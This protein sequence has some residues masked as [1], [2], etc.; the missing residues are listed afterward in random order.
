M[1]TSGINRWEANRRR[2]RGEMPSLRRNA[3]PLADRRF[4]LRIEC[5]APDQTR[6]GL[7]H[8]RKALFV[9]YL[10]VDQNSAFAGHAG[11]VSSRPRSDSRE[12]GSRDEIVKVLRAVE[13][14]PLRASTSER[15]PRDF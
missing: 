4:K 9:Q 12:S 2:A 8:K 11:P 6:G 15:R 14:A 5:S 13:A 1:E 3:I 7:A 10:C